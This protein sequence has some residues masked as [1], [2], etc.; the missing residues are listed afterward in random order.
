[1]ALRLYLRSAQRA[2]SKVSTRAHSR[3]TGRWP[4][5]FLDVSVRRRQSVGLD[6]C[7]ALTR[8]CHEVQNLLLLLLEI[9]TTP[10]GSGSLREVL[11]NHPVRGLLIDI[12]FGKDVGAAIA[13]SARRKPDQLFVIEADVF[14]A[15]GLRCVLLLHVLEQRP[16]ALGGLPLAVSG[17]R[18]RPVAVHG[19]SAISSGGA[20]DARSRMGRV[21]S[22]RPR[23]DVGLD[24]RLPQSGRGTVL[25]DHIVIIYRGRN[26]RHNSTAHRRII[27]IMRPW[28]YYA[29]HATRRARGTTLVEMDARCGSDRAGWNQIW[30]VGTNLRETHL[31]QST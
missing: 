31:W 27:I 14:D 15:G 5:Y 26:A 17:A 12:G 16:T 25:A 9:P 1:M 18:I 19:G 30:W 28:H 21:L 7:G 3:C 24:L 11:R 22:L 4:T 20:A 29:A 23:W 6:G 2:R 13:P 8:A 10:N